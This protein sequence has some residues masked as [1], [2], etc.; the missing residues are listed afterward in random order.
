[1][2]EQ[3]LCRE[4]L[5]Y[6]LWHL[7][8]LR[9]TNTR[10]GHT[11]S[12]RSNVVDLRVPCEVFGYYELLESNGPSRLLLCTGVKGYTRSLLCPC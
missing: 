5:I 4:G 7:L 8:R 6:M 9:L 10:V 1:M 11:V 12:C 2:G 3:A